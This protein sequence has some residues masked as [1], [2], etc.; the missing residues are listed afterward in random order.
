VFKCAARAHVMRKGNREH[1]PISDIKDLVD[2]GKRELADPDGKVQR[3]HFFEVDD[4]EVVQPPEAEQVK[5]SRSLYAYRV[6][7]STG[8]NLVEARPFACYCDGCIRFAECHRP[9]GP[10]RGTPAGVLT[11]APDSSD[12]SE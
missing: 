11:Q 8:S 7:G 4:S 2:F 10:W 1:N 6:R 5:G 3:R 9:G 12:T